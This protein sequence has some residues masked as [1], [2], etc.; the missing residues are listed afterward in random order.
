MRIAAVIHQFPPDATTGTEILCLRSA[1]ALIARGHEVRVFSGDRNAPAGTPPR[2]ETVEGVDVRRIGSYRPPRLLLARRMAEEFSNPQAARHLVAAVGAL[3]PDVIH[4]YQSQQFGLAV[5]PELAR[6][7]PVLSTVTD[8]HLV[9]PLVTA[10][11][12]DGSPCDGPGVDGAAC[13]AHLRGRETARLE[14][15]RGATRAMLAVREGFRRLPAADTPARLTQAMAGRLR[16]S[17]AA[18]S[19]A[20][21]TLVGPPRLYDMLK[22]RFGT[23]VQQFG[24]EAPPL[25]VPPRP[26]GR[27]LS[28]GYFSSLSHHKGL[29]VLL[30]AIALIPQDVAMTFTICGP[31]GPDAAYV[32]EMTTRAAADSRIALTHGVPHHQMGEALGAAD[33]VVIPSLWDENNPLVLLDALEAGRYVVASAAPGMRAELAEPRGG[34]AVPPG[35]AEALAAALLALAADP[36]AVLRARAQPVRASRFAG[37]IEAIEAHYI[38]LAAG[39][40]ACA[41]RAS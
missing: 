38:A 40:P 9:C 34:V 13:I 32:R 8:F 21:L 20:G 4:L 16:A 2:A 3:A 18:I 29:H 6:I 36:G 35:N 1:Q 41:A 37:Y 17:E 14:T 33:I 24:H 28:V 12:E 23:R 7:A 5:V 30:D 26:V 27:T 11:L 31:P 19:A 39:R 10:A 22:T 25:D 15:E